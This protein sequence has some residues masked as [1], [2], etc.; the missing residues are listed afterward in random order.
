LDRRLGTRLYTVTANPAYRGKISPRGPI[1][2]I[3]AISFLMSK[4]P[5]ELKSFA[6]KTLTRPIYG[7][8]DLTARQCKQE[9]AY[10]MSIE[11]PMLRLPT[12]AG[13]DKMISFIEKVWRRLG[14]DGRNVQKEVERKY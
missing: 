14:R 9:V 8:C 7:R 4:L 5:K 10:L 12:D 11:M 6:T 3:S 13:V 2:A 1:S